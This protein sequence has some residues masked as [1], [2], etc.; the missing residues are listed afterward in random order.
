MRKVILFIAACLLLGTTASYAQ[1][2]KEQH[3]ERKEIRKASKSQLNAKASK[4]ARKEAKK[5]KKDG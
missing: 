3:K 5:M 2:T 1:L 4:V